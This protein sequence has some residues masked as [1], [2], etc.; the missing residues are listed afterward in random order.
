VIKI[1]DFLGGIAKD[2]DESGVATEKATLPVPQR[3]RQGGLVKEEV[4]AVRVA[5]GGS[6]SRGMDWV[7]GVHA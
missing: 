3:H 4:K 7:S 5:S 1:Q 6:L 2:A